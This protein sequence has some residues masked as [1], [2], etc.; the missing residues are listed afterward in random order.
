MSCASNVARGIPRAL[1]LGVL[2]TVGFVAGRAE[3]AMQE[4]GLPIVPATRTEE[5]TA[6]ELLKQ[7]SPRLPVD[8]EASVVI[9]GRARRQYLPPSWTAA[10]FKDDPTMSLDPTFKVRIFWIVSRANDCHY[11]LGHQ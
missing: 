5:K 7:R 8:G 1:A 10:D 9:N 2:A 11:C 3:G 6:L 4:E